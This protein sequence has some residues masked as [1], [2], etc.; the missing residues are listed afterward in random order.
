MDHRHL[1][2]WDLGQPGTQPDAD[3]AP[4][5][6]PDHHTDASTVGSTGARPQGKRL[7][8]EAWVW[9]QSFHPK[10]WGPNNSFDGMLVFVKS[11]CF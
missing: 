9:L 5:Y 1:P 6:R 11:E 4:S 3:S 8:T 10:Q 7:V 2:S